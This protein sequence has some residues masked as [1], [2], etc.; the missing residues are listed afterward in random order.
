[1]AINWKAAL[2]PVSQS[3]EFKPAAV[4]KMSASA[5]AAASMDKALAAF[6]G[7]N[8]DIKRPT[9]VK[10][11]D[12]VKFSVRYANTALKLDGKESEFVVPA[13]KFE[14]IYAAIKGAVLAGE[15]DSQLAPLEANSKARGQKMAA[16]KKAAK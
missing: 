5:R 14:E 6:K 16:A 8:A 7:G 11:G 1:M 4:G 10:K 13:D 12:E 2:K 9:I 3:K 15:F